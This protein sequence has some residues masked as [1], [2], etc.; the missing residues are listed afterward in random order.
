MDSVAEATLVDG[1]GVAGSVGRSKRRQV[2]ILSQEDWSAAVDAAGADA[3]PSRRRANILVSGMRLEN[4]RGRVLVIGNARV[5]VGGE[6][7][8]CERMEEVAVG[9][10]N[11]LRPHWRAG[12]FGQVSTGGVVRVGDVVRWE[13]RNKSK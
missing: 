13:E 10:Q 9:L 4:T 7:T 12:V 6:L 2:S 1:E 3:D 5:T 8:P 11:A